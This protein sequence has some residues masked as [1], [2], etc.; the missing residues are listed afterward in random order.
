ML[1]ILLVEDHTVVRNGLKMLLEA[2]D[3]MSIIAEAENGRQ[4]LDILAANQQVDLVLCDINMPEMDGITMTAAV[5]A[6]DFRAKVILLSMADSETAVY[7]AFSAG[8]YAYLLKS[9]SVEELKF[10]LHHVNSG[11]QY[12]CS[13]LAM[14]QLSMNIQRKLVPTAVSSLDFELSS[15]E[16]E[17]L[18]LLARGMTN[19]QM[20]DKLFIS[21]RTVEGH[22]QSLIDKFAVRNTAELI[23]N[24]VR[25]GLIS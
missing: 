7:E 3:T 24:S 17:V 2:D 25:A 22:R 15:R 18:D 9:S 8:A 23:L 14:R 11:Q 19:Q 16:Q 21:K 10:A 12:L 20:S 4:A 13:N 6:L 1:Q 5:K